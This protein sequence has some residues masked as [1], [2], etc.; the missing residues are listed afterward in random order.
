MRG[1]AAL[2]CA[3]ALMACA[4]AAA[5]PE[6]ESVALETIATM[7]ARAQMPR[8]AQAL[9]AYDRYYAPHRIDDGN[10]VRGVFLLR[11]S[12]GDIDRPGMTAVPEMQN[13][14][15]GAA[16][17]IPVVADGGCAVVT[18]YFDVQLNHFLQLEAA[19]RDH[20]TA[21]SLCNGEA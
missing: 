14:Y 11:S 9:E 3:A 8:G 10:V 16:E 4:T 18:M 20:V 13:V 21:P 19:A 17:D 7:E 6:A 12:F 1:L 15:R 5:E 2:V